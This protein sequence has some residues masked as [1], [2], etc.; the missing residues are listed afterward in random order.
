[1]KEF[2]KFTTNRKMETKRQNETAGERRR[3]AQDLIEQGGQR[4]SSNREETANYLPNPRE[5]RLA[6]DRAGT[7]AEDARALNDK[8]AEESTQD[9]QARAPPR[10]ARFDQS[11]TFRAIDESVHLFIKSDQGQWAHREMAKIATLCE[12]FFCAS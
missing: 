12:N 2:L 10:N 3:L 7:A 4:R 9:P 6:N 8:R 5:Q 1:M 11:S